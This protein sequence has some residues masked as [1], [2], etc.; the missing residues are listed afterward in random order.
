[1]NEEE[2][3]QKGLKMRHLMMIA[4]GGSIGAGLFVGSGAIIQMTG[5]AAVFTALMAGILVILVMRML[6]EMVVAKPSLGSFSDYAREALGNWAGF[7]VGWLYWYFWVIVIAVEAI[8]G[9]AILREWLFP[10]VSLWALNLILLVVLTITNLFSVKAYGEFEYWFSLIKIVAI[11]LFLALG[12]AYVLGLL[13]NTTMDF[14][15]LTAHGGFAPLGSGAVFVAVATIIFSF[16]GS[17]IVTIAASESAESEKAV[18]KAV[19]SVIVRIMT[20]Y[21]GSVFLI[22]AIVPWNDAK[23]LTNPYV[24]ALKVIGIPGAD[25][26]M[27]LV[28]V[29]AVLSCLNSGIY[30]ASRMLF[31]LGDK[32][33]APRWMMDVTKSGVPLKAILTCTIFGFLSVIMAFI[34][35]DTVFQFLLNSSGAIAIFVY[36]LI[37]IS[38]LRLRKKIEREMPERL[39][40]RMWAYPYLTIGSILAMVAIIGSMAFN[41]STR[42]QLILSLL[43]AIIVALFYVIKANIEKKKLAKANEAE[44]ELSKVNVKY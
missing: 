24:S 6:G 28:V 12:G 22:V 2:K 43:S 32:G 27:N 40:L 9:A 31:A 23:A 30:T 8:A 7:T 41:A 34:S 35:P 20:F 5:P 10:H 18:V 19:N 26:I 13:P 21:V 3:L 4:F 44:N 16:V 11:I 25:M 17:E 1:M 38:Q 15:N 14:S 29:T 37:A 42:S 36:L 39:K 33:D